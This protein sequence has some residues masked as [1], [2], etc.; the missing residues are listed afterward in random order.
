M[1][2]APRARSNVIRATPRRFAACFSESKLGCLFVSCMVLTH[3]KRYAISGANREYGRVI[4]LFHWDETA[5]L[6]PTLIISASYMITKVVKDDGQNVCKIR[7]VELKDWTEQVWQS[8]RFLIISWLSTWLTLVFLGLKVALDFRDEAI[9][10]F[11]GIA[12]LHLKEVGHRLLALALR[13][14]G[15]R[16]ILQTEFLDLNALR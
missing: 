10:I 6:L 5:V 3:H 14:P 9:N 1:R 8:T 4:D 13:H 2:P 15:F 16:P 12:R 7:H 11:R